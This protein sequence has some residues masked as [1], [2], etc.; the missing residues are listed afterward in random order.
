MVAH[1]MGVPLE[2][3]IVQLAP[4]GLATVTVVAVAGR[5]ALGRVRRRLRHRSDS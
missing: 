3:T 1:V 2:E 5:A 4:A